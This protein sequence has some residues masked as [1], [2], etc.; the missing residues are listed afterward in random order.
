MFKSIAENVCD[1]HGDT[2]SNSLGILWPL[3]GFLLYAVLSQGKM[4]FVAW[5]SNYEQ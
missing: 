3:R 1:S 5:S 2:V 4:G